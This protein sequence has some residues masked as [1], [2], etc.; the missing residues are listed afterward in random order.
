MFIEG[1][2]VFNAG[3]F[4]ECHAV[5]E[6][7]WLEE[8]RPERDLYKGLIQL[9]GGYY[10]IE[11]GNGKGALSLLTKGPEL[12]APFA[13]L[14]MGLQIDS[15]LEQAVAARNHVVAA[16]EGQPLQPLPATL[17]PRWTWAR[18]PDTQECA[19]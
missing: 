19:D 11:R 5:L 16:S 15:C 10:H 17:A 2:A 4:W 13:P 18:T 8:H 1:V 14:C 9:A 6:P 12:L 7:L 3:E